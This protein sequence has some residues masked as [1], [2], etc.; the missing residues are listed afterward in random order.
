MILKLIVA[1][2]LFAMPYTLPFSWKFFV[3]TPLFLMVGAKIFGVKFAVNFNLKAIIFFVAISLALFIA[4]SFAIN[5]AVSKAGLQTIQNGSLL[6]VISPVFQSLHEEFAI[7]SLLLK[8]ANKIGP[9]VSA[10]L[11]ANIFAL[12]HYVLYGFG[13]EKVQLDFSVLVTLFSFGL[14]ANLLFLEGQN[15][16]LPYL[17]HVCWNLARFRNLLLRDG[18]I[19]KE[20]VTFNL[21]EGSTPVLTLSICFLVFGLLFYFRNKSRIPAGVALLENTN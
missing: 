7:R 10:V 17:F 21:I 9:L 20:G 19:L 14:G 2:I 18:E 8:C 3:L 11:L 16:F 12:T 4:S 1:L 5:N 13:F 15:L 6:W